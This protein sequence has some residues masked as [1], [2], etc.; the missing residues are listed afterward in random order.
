MVVEMWEVGRRRRR[1]VSKHI[2]IDDQS[3]FPFSLRATHTERE[4]RQNLEK[5]LP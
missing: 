1:R 2:F 4:E 5:D 3:Q